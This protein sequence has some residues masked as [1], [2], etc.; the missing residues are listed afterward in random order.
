MLFTSEIPISMM[1]AGVKGDYN[2]YINTYFQHPGYDY[3]ES[4]YN[5]IDNGYFECIELGIPMKQWMPRKRGNSWRIIPEMQPDGMGGMHKGLSLAYM[6][7]TNRTIFV[8]H[9]DTLASSLQEYYSFTKFGEHANYETMCGLSYDEKWMG[10][11][12]WVRTFRRW[13]MCRQMHRLGMKVHL[14]G[15]NSLFELWLCKKYA[16]SADSSLPI[17]AALAHK[18]LGW[19]KKYRQFKG[20]IEHQATQEEIELA[21]RNIEKA[22][23]VLK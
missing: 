20:F 5:I 23:K 1:K 6:H 4:E 13:K 22:I 14:L 2:F 10:K 12:K 18:K 3:K 17:T 21:K 8:S 16:Y 19:F 9:S 11:N 15:C 7:V